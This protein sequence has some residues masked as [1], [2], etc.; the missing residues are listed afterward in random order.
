MIVV[1]MATS[2][3]WDGKASFQG[4]ECGLIVALG[5]LGNMLLKETICIFLGL[6]ISDVAAV[7]VGIEF[8]VD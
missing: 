7:V 6:E 3:C 5:I 2:N 1:K 4:A 8:E